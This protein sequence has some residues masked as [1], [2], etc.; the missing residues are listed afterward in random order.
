MAAAATSMTAAAG[1]AAGPALV[2]SICLIRRFCSELAEFF[3]WA[4]AGTI[5]VAAVAGDWPFAD[6]I[7]AAR[8]VSEVFTAAVCDGNADLASVANVCALLVTLFRQK[9]EVSGHRLISRT[10]GPQRNA[11]GS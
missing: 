10:K 3:T 2:M 7:V 1:S 9:W 6:L 4:T 5:A 8:V 11:F